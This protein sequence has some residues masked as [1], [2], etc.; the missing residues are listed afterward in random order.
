MVGRIIAKYEELDKQAAKPVQE[1]KPQKSSGRVINTVSVE[2]VIDHI[3][4]P[5]N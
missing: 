5:E 2:A 3:Y 4:T 1:I